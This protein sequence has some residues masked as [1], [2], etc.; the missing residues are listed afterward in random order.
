MAL[1]VYAEVDLLPDAP[2][3]VELLEDEQGTASGEDTTPPEQNAA[4]PEPEQSAEPEQPAPTETPEPTAAPALTPAPAATATAPP[5]PTL[6]PT[7][8]PANQTKKTKTMVFHRRQR[9]ALYQRRAPVF[10]LEAPD[11]TLQTQPAMRCSTGKAQ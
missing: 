4:T 6:P 8:T 7:A 3:E 5:G 9:P 10:R 1:P 2:D 11:G